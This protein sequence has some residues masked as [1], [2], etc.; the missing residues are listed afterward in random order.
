MIRIKGHSNF[1]LA[2]LEECRETKPLIRKSSNSPPDS[3]RLIRQCNKQI[4]FVEKNIKGITSPQV[5]SQSF[6]QNGFYFDMEYLPHSEFLNFLIEKP[7]LEIKK[8]IDTILD[9]VDQCVN[10]SREELISSDIFLKKS[11]SIKKNL[12]NNKFINN[13]NYKKMCL[14]LDDSIDRCLGSSIPT[15]YC[16]GD[17]TLS[18]ILYS[19]GEIVFID[20][21]DSFIETPLQDIVKL[22]QD[23]KHFWSLRLLSGNHDTTKLKIVLRYIDNQIQ[24]RFSC[25][26]FYKALYASFQSISLIRVAQYAKS[27]STI[28]YIFT[29]LENP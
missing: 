26:N 24:Y 5:F 2:V 10:E 11:K 3:T 16:H 9:F 20:F 23:T 8:S 1:N 21:L 19:N 25:Y 12:K 13:K 15:G 4:V 18:N 27:H 14:V 29:C 22:R 28:D 17:L 7:I 6:N